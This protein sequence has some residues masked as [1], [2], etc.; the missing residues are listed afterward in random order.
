MVGDESWVSERSDL[1]HEGQDRHE[2]KQ[3]VHE[4]PHPLPLQEHSS[5]SHRKRLQVLDLNNS[6]EEGGQITLF[7]RIFPFFFFFLSCWPR[8]F[9]SLPHVRLCLSHRGQ[10]GGCDAR[11][12][13]HRV[14]RSRRAVLLDNRRAAPQEAP[15]LGVRPAQP[16]QHGPFQEEAHLVC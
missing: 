14:P 15:H 7:Q 16:Q 10:F 8:L 12:Q 9:Q 4:R 1:L 13:D 11:P 6:R 3:R 5:P 2:L